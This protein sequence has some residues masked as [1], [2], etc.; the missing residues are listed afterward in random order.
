VGEVAEQIQVV[1]VELA[2]PERLAVAIVEV[3]ES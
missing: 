1:L 3:L 2:V